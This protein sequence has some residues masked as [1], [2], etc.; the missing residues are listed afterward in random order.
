LGRTI[1]L[2]RHGRLQA[3]DDQKRFVGQID[4][5]LSRQGI[6]QAENIRR[7]FTG[8]K[9]DVYC[10]DLARSRQTAE[11][12]VEGTGWALRTRTDFREISVG[13]WEGKTF[14]EIALTYPEEFEERGEDI[15]HYCPPQGE[16]FQECST[17][18]VAAFQEIVEMSGGDIA[19]VGHAGVNRLLLCYLLG[20]PV[21]NLFRLG[22]DYGC[23]NIITYAKQQYRVETMN[24]SL[25]TGF[26]I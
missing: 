22:Q 25:E 12:I 13:L 14:A 8:N 15:E 3:A 1:Y 20:M 18:V 9:L 16:S 11:H 5:P 23:I 7:Y 4:L 17:R 26:N 24:L 2:V 21:R 19:I 10:S 6:E